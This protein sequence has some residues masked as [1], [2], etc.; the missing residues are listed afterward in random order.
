MC[1]S[2]ARIEGG[3]LDIAEVARIPQADLAIRHPAELRNVSHC[4]SAV[5]KRH[6]RP[7]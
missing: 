7:L 1:N 2:R 3:H 6:S 4:N 5:K